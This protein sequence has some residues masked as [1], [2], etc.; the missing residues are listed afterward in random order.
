MKKSTGMFHTAVAGT[1]VGETTPSHERNQGPQGPQGNH[2]FKHER[3]KVQ[4]KPCLEMK[5]LCLWG[6]IPFPSCESKMKATF[7]A[8]AG[9][10]EQS[11]RCVH[12]CSF[13]AFVLLFH[14]LNFYLFLNG[15][16]PPLH[17]PQGVDIHAFLF[18]ALLSFSAVYFMCLIIFLKVLA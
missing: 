13:S 3:N 12:D 4:E 11:L 7:Q 1:D 17:G 16:T 2:D 14:L 9:L 18:W 10:C 5:F 15:N 8:W 6:I